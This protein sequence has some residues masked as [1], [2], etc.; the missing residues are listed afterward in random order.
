MKAKFRIFKFANVSNSKAIADRDL[1]I[2]AKSKRNYCPF[3]Q[4][5]HIYDL[6]LNL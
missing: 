3:R 2:K 4:C 1:V 6:E 5:D